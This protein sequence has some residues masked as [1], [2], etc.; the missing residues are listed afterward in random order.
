MMLIRWYLRRHRQKQ[1]EQLDETLLCNL[2]HFR[3]LNNTQK[4]YEMIHFSQGT[5][6]L[7]VL[8][9]CHRYV[10][11]VCCE[12]GINKGSQ[13]SVIQKCLTYFY[14]VV[15]GMLIKK[16][17]IWSRMNANWC[18]VFVYI[19]LINEKRR[20]EA[21]HAVPSRLSFFPRYDFGISICVCRS[22][23]LASWG[24]REGGQQVRWWQNKNRKK[25]FEFWGFFLSSLLLRHCRTTKEETSGENLFKESQ[26]RHWS[27]QSR[28]HKSRQVNKS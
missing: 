26:S 28:G 10:L 18:C 27:R 9:S 2:E 5:K 16:R 20:K 8:Q 25:Y 21:F 6:I 13:E 4:R 17:A 12:W 23:S 1:Q 14:G 22:H 19:A 15:S 24:R 7:H 11:C 3:H